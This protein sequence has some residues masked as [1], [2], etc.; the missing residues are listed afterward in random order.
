MR[1]R[2]DSFLYM[3]VKISRTQSVHQSSLFAA[4]TMVV[5]ELL[6][7]VQFFWKNA[8]NVPNLMTVRMI[9]CPGCDTNPI[10]SPKDEPDVS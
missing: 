4:R 7:P 9:K 2:P 10:N 8:M 6:A 1:P 3:F 5:L